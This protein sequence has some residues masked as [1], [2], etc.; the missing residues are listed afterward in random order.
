M[1]TA[2]QIFIALFMGVIVGVIYLQL[3]LSYP[4]GVQNRIGALFFIIQNQI[5]SN[6]SA[7]ELFIKER[8]V[9]VHESASGFYRVSSYFF[10]KIFSDFIPMRL[11][12]LIAFSI[13]TYFMIGLQMDVSKFFIFFLTLFLTTMCGSAI[14]FMMS[15]TVRVFAVANLLCILTFIM[16]MV[17]NQIA[18]VSSRLVEFNCRRISVTCQRC[19]RNME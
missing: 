11:L 17:A 7:V 14:C 13:I 6:M 16:M 19:S 2:L 3:D 5:F 12:P 1:A 8:V 4:A 15:A 9:F 10:A 18:R